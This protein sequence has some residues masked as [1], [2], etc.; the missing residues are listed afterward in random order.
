MRSILFMC[1]PESCEHHCMVMVAGAVTDF[2]SRFGSHSILGHR[3]VAG[4]ARSVII[5]ALQALYTNGLTEVS[6]AGFKLIK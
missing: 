2:N 1:L 4:C 3:I 6:D 5:S